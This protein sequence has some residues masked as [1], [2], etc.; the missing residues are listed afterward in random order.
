MPLNDHYRVY[1]QASQGALD[2]YSQ[3]KPVFSRSIDCG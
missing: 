2:I 3:A 1:A